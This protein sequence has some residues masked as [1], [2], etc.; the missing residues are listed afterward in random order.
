M[1]PAKLIPIWI[2]FLQAL[3]S[4]PF[5]TECHQ[6]MFEL[7]F[8]QNSC[9]VVSHGYI[10]EAEVKE[11]EEKGGCVG[12]EDTVYLTGVI[13]DKI[14]EKRAGCGKKEKNG[15]K[16]RRRRCWRGEKGRELKGCRQ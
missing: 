2:L 3:A 6:T 7:I 15:R 4:Q 1:N 14:E 16:M 8:S 5:I 9:H 10:H 12:G 13:E 11:E